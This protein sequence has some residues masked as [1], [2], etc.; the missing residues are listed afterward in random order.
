MTKLLVEHIS[1]EHIVCAMLH[2][3][4]PSPITPLK[5]NPKRET[6]DNAQ[7]PPLGL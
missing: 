2:I 1:N 4:F 3:K 7:R 6:L 5:K